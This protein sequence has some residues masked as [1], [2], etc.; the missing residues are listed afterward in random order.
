MRRHWVLVTIVVLT[1][2]G[3]ASSSEQ[4][5]LPV[6]TS[7]PTAVP[8]PGFVCGAWATLTS[9]RGVR[10]VS[11]LSD[12]TP[13]AY[14]QFPRILTP[15][16]TGTI[17]V[18][19]EVVGDVP[20]AAFRRNV[21]SLEAG[22]TSEIWTRSSTR[23]V[24]GRLVSVF[25][26]RYPASILADLL[27]YA[28]GNDF[29]QIPLGRLELPGSSVTDLNGTQPGPTFV[30]VWLRLAPSNLP[31][32]TVRAITSA[33]E[34]VPTAQYASHVVN[35]VV[36]GFGD[37]QVL[38]GAQA[39]E[40]EA[41]AQ[42]FYQHFAD[43]YHTLSFIPRRSPFW[44]YAAFNINVKND[45]EGVGAA[46]VDDQ[47]AYG[48]ET[49]RSVQ[50][51]AAGF[52]GQQEA[53]VHQ[54]AHHWGD[55]TD[56]AGIAGVAGAG[57]QPES[58]TPLLHG[59]ATLIGAVLEGTREVER[60]P[61]TVVG[62]DDTYRIVRTRAPVTFHP[63]QLYRMGF[64][65]PA[66]V[67]DVIVFT[68]QAQFSPNT[69]SAP[70]VGTPVTGERHTVNIN[71]IMAALGSRRGPSFTEWRQA[72]VV[73]SDELIS[74][75]EMDYYNFY[76]QRVA[77][78]TGTRSYE[79][80]G[81]FVEA[82][83]H[84]VRLRT[85]I[86]TRDPGG[87]PKITQ[88]LAVSDAPFG[89]RDWRGLVFDAP[90]P[91]RVAAGASLTLSGSIDTDLLPG[92]HQYVVFRAARYGDAPSAAITVQTKVSGGRFTV[93]LRFTGDQTGAY[94][95]DAFVFVD[96]DSPAITTSVMTPLFVH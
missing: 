58:H 47:A 45:V 8:R 69:A 74:E 36:P 70:A 27:I 24:D 65:E 80:F 93:P 88:T 52:A 31:V 9:F 30:T 63:L 35:I 38:N 59:G 87:N 75:M 91:S 43:N 42:A 16:E 92:S 40:F 12:N 5:G 95:I 62:G 4:R 81:S 25:D 77:A 57:R 46:L 85:D 20:T 61:S 68:G 2:C 26:E 94:A 15:T 90:V 11:P 55:E 33:D 21:P 51:Y 50:L 37:T 22:Y 66:A 54:T 64:L 96:A 56:L 60:V 86:D 1:L 34:S 53:T 48:S 72:F 3:A 17:R 78:V 76:A 32:S 23:T 7:L 71:Q 18:V 41:A 73:V 79:G 14:E 82:T 84:R 13:L 29:P 10:T 49:L 44:A 67:P 83:G 39:F 28:H 89:S 19:A 6:G